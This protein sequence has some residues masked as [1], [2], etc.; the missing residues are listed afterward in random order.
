MTKLHKYMY[1]YLIKTINV[2]LARWTTHDFL[3]YESS[4]LDKNRVEI[5]EISIVDTSETTTSIRNEPQYDKTNKL[6][7]T[8]IEDSDQLRYLPSQIS[9][10]CALS[11]Y[12]RTQGFFMRT[13]NISNQSLKLRL[14]A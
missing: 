9:L 6:T 4:A 10:C 1:M 5:T 12:L 8:P 14:S 3:V 11:G 2:L 13:V 7:C